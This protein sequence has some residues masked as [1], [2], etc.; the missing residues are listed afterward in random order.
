MTTEVFI[1][2]NKDFSKPLD[3]DVPDADRASRDYGSERV[4]F[5]KNCQLVGEA[6]LTPS[7]EPVCVPFNF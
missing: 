4:Q 2:R 7:Q 5:F 6:T 1:I 3:V